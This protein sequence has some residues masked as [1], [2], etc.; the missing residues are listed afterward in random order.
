MERRKTFREL[1]KED[2]MM[3]ILED[4]TLSGL[5][6]K[7]FTV[8]DLDKDFLEYLKR[9]I[10]FSKYVIMVV[11]LENAEEELNGEEPNVFELFPFYEFDEMLQQA[12][13]DEY[14]FLFFE[15]NSN[16]VYIINIGE[17]S[18][19]EYKINLR[20][21]MQIIIGTY[22]K[23]YMLE[24]IVTCSEVYSGI[25]NIVIAYEEAKEIQQFVSVSGLKDVHFYDE[26]ENYHLKPILPVEE[27]DK[28]LVNLTRT[29]DREALHNFLNLIIDDWVK[30]G[31]S[32]YTAQGIACSIFCQMSTAMESYYDF[33]SVED[34][35]KTLSGIVKEKSIEKLR[36]T[37]LCYADKYCSQVQQLSMNYQT[38]GIINRIEKSMGEYLFDEGLNISFLAEKVGL[39]AKYM[40]ALY[41]ER[42]GKN[43]LEV[44]NRKRIDRFKELIKDGTTI[45]KAAE[46]CGYC[47]MVTLNRWFKKIEG[48]T[49]GKIKGSYSY[50]SR[51]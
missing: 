6:R 44:I 20:D 28:R 4:Y 19:N 1:Q 32:I 42:T 16:P 43:L 24:A 35:Q 23:K 48:T 31:I 18:I 25:E 36:K 49:P 38:Q 47:S 26:S 14:S 9:E 12:L 15:V 40:A 33:D 21:A 39:N 10:S 22:R 13:T 7:R 41:E 8:K 3:R 27:I 2:Q 5:V 34:F 37:L 30:Q 11:R 17:S 50:I 45:K 29:G 51:T 46:E